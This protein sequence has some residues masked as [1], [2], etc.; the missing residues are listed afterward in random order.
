MQPRQYRRRHACARCIQLKVKCVPVRDTRSCERCTRLSHACIFPES[1]RPSSNR[2]SRIDVL[3]EQVDKLVAELEATKQDSDKHAPCQPSKNQTYIVANHQYLEGTPGKKSSFGADTDQD[4]ISRGLFT[5]LEC[6]ELLA[7]FR[8]HK[9]PQFPFVIVPTQLGVPTL[10]QEFPFLL[11]CIITASLEHKPSLQHHMEHEVRKVIATRLIINMERN[12][13]LLLGLLIHIAWYHY[14]WRTYHT[15][16]YML[17]QMAIMVVVA[18][19]L[20]KDGNFRTQT[21]PFDK[22]GVD[23]T[24][25]HGDHWTPAGQRALLGCYYLCL[26]SSLFRRQ[27][28]MRHTE[29]IERCTK[30]LAERTEYPTDLFLRTYIDVRSLAQIS[31]SLFEGRTPSSVQG[32]DWQQL[33][34][35]TEVREKRTEE[36]LRQY[37]LWDNWALRMELSAIPVLVLGHAL[38]RHKDVFHLHSTREL[39][40]LTSSAYNTVNIFLT[41]PSTGFVHLPASSYNTLRYSLMVLSKLS[42]LSETQLEISQIRKDNMREIGLAL[43]RKLG[44]ISQDED[45]WA[46]CNKVVGSMLLWLENNSSQG[47]LT[48]VPRS[49]GINSGPYPHL[50]LLLAPQFGPSAFPG[51]VR[52]DWNAG[53]WE[54]MLEELTWLGPSAEV[55]LCT[56]PSLSFS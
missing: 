9:M 13:D 12:M 26:K 49:Q 19:G 39:S 34:G 31:Q 20:D 37:N 27:F 42:L 22:R 21:I 41:I 54:Q 2:K 28:I 53:I 36:L 16:V 11:L 7:K 17:L 6:E 33:F 35:L 15:Q 30:M 14:H 51:D 1:P 52:D 50:E 24:E 32:M 3:Q 29:W 47:H 44:D 25:G 23:Q 48:Q 5:L 46:N 18:L 40:Y 56:G 8:T 10:R 45:V 55:R 38:G 4:F 43:I